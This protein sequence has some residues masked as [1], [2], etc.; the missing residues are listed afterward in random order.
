MK[1]DRDKDEEIERLRNRIEQL[2][3]IIADAEDAI[4]PGGFDRGS[5]PIGPVIRAN[6]HNLRLRISRLEL[7]IFELQ[8]ELE[9]LRLERGF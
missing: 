6:L 1:D 4:C 2:E 9:A 8:R 3:N 7:D 5:P